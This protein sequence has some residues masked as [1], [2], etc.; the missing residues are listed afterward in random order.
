MET[1]PREFFDLEALNTVSGAAVAVYAIV[2]F[3]KPLIKRVLPDWS[4]RFYVLA[5]SWAVLIFVRSL[6]VGL[7]TQTLGLVLLDGFVVAFA[8]MGFHEA[9]RDPKAQKIM[10]L[11]K[12][13]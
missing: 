13:K 5:L 1:I 7:S 8:A 2:R 4:I 9:I 11:D 3:T 6:T 10:P 12:N